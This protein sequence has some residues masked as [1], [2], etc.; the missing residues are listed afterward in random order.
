MSNLNT[1][2]TRMEALNAIYFSKAIANINSLV[3]EMIEDYWFNFRNEV[4][5]KKNV[6]V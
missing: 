1:V 6:A 4:L 5:N 2:E 3:I